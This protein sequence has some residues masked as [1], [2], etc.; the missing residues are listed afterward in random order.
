MQR[1]RPMMATDS[2]VRNPGFASAGMTNIGNLPATARVP[3]EKRSFA[4]HHAL[5]AETSRNGRRAFPTRSEASH[6]FISHPRRLAAS[7]ANQRGGISPTAM[8]WGSVEHFAL[9]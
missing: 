5:E 4:N 1:W 3:G 8:R 2:N 9:G 7:A 6:K